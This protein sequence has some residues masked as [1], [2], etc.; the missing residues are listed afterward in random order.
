M[1]NCPW[2][3]GKL[4]KPPPHP[5]RGVCVWGGSYFSSIFWFINIHEYANEMILCM[6]I[7]WKDLSNRITDDIITCNKDSLRAEFS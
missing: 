6:T 2:V 4:N 5:P 3:Q 1:S 7:G